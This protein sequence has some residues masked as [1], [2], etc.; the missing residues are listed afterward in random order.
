MMRDV[1]QY[2]AVFVQQTHVVLCDFS[3]NIILCRANAQ[4]HLVSILQ[5][6]YKHAKTYKQQSL[7]IIPV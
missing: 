5:K 4:T 7:V 1:I 3:A 6:R 2:P